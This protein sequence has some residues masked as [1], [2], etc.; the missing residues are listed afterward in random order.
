MQVFFPVGGGG[1]DM[2]YSNSLTLVKS[3]K[4]K[5][6]KNEARCHPPPLFCLP[7]KLTRIYP[8]TSQYHI[9]YIIDGK[10]SL[11]QGYYKAP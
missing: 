2:N 5:K 9:L 4:C 1:R 3:K 7:L 8:G 6:K 10:H 11:Q